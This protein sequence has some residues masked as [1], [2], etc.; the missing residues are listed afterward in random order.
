MNRMAKRLKGEAGYLLFLLPT[1]ILMSLFVFYP[2]LRGIPYSF[3]NWDGFSQN[4]DF[5][6]F[7]NYARIF[8]DTA[9][10]RVLR[11]TLLFTL[12]QTVCCN[13]LGLLLALLFKRSGRGAGLMK[14]LVFTPYVISLVLSSYMIQNLLYEACKA[15]GLTNPLAVP[16][17]IIPGLSMIAIWRDSGYC[18]IIYLA[19]LMNVDESLYESATVDGA[20]PVRKFFSI[21]VP[22]I[23][24]A[25]TANVTLLLSWG[26]KLFDYSM[27]AVKG[28]FSESVNVYVYRLIF[29]GYRAGYGQAI[30]ILW[31]II[32]FLLTNCIAMALR[33]REVEL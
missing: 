1:L 5:V 28:D 17:L 18:M 2:L 20:N 4:M 15:L 25:F 23:V 29:P 12:L 21:T 27:T 14:T 30:A 9:M 7:K 10:P 11:N 32:I 33:K 8:R 3:T 19:A 31:T 26:L 22:L 6:G 16:S 13:A 24:P